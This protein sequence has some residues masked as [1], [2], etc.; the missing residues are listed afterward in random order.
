MPV[1]LKEKWAKYRQQLRDIPQDWPDVP[2]DLI[3]HPNAPNDD[4]KDVLFEDVDHPVIKIAD[5][6]DED[7]LMLKQFVKGVK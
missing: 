1:D 3:R 7:K 4:E 5:R 6:T 2:V